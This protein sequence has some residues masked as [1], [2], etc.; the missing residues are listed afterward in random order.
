MR[1]SAKAKAQLDLNLAP[2]GGEVSED[3]E[4]MFVRAC[5]SCCG[6]TSATSAHARELPQATKATL[7]LQATRGAQATQ[8]AQALNATHVP[9]LLYPALTS[10]R[11]ETRPPR[12][13]LPPGCA[14]YA[15]EIRICPVHG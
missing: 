3:R 6:I 1:A 13:R 2:R 9:A 12:R 11:A 7:I 5:A 4:R 8:A 14:V 15:G 10:A